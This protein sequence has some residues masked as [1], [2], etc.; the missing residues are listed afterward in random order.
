MIIFPYFRNSNSLFVESYFDSGFELCEF[1]RFL[2]SI[3]FDYLNYGHIRSFVTDKIE[4]LVLDSS[5]KPVVASIPIKRI[6]GNSKQSLFQKSS[7]RYK[8][9][10]NVLKG[11]LIHS[12]SSINELMKFDDVTSYPL[13]FLKSNQ[14]TIGQNNN[15]SLAIMMAKSKLGQKNYQILIEKLHKA[16]QN[17]NN[18]VASIDVMNS[19]CITLHNFWLSSVLQELQSGRQQSRLREVLSESA[20]GQAVE[21]SMPK[22]VTNGSNLSIAIDLKSSTLQNFRIGMTDKNDDFLSFSQEFNPNSILF[23]NSNLFRTPD[24]LKSPLE[25]VRIHRTNDSDT[26][27]YYSTVSFT[28]ITR[29][30]YV[31]ILEPCDLALYKVSTFNTYPDSV[32]IFDLEEIKKI[33]PPNA[34]AF[35]VLFNEIKTVGDQYVREYTLMF[36]VVAFIQ[37]RNTDYSIEQVPIFTECLKESLKKQRISFFAT[38][39]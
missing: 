28:D 24:S 1:S 30:Q 34:N 10:I 5:D 4:F 20:F 16:N 26:N 39:P 6:L 33:C 38:F 2:K 31:K 18:H 13:S 21:I 15:S 8:G 29:S 11:C 35:E 19:I 25:M 36:C 7:Q 23:K 12:R 17:L 22:V 27:G 9:H 3:N 32:Q 37:S 14:I